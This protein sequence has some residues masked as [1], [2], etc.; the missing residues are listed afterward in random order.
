MSANRPTP[1]LTIRAV[2]GG[3]I[4]AGADS[5]C[6]LPQDIVPAGPLLAALVA[7]WAA[8]CE[9]DAAGREDALLPG[10]PTA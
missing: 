7:E 10:V 1:T 9:V 2:P 4:V 3:F 5:P 8:W 6:P